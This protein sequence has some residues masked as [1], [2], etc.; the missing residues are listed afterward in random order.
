MIAILDTALRDAFQ[1]WFEIVPATDAGLRDEAFRLR[2]AVYCEDLA[3]EAPRADGREQDEYDAQSTHI[4]IRHRPSA[5]FVGCVRLIR[6]PAGGEQQRLPFERVCHGL[7][8]GAVPD[9]PERRARIAEVSRLAVSRTFR[10]RRGEANRAAPVS[11]GDFSG[12]PVLRFPYVLVG[13][14]LGVVA[15]AMLHDI[16]RLF[17]LTEPRLGEHL[18]RLGLRVVR[19]GPAVEHR[20]L[21]VPSMIDVAP[22][23]ESL[24]PMG[25]PLYEHVLASLEQAYAASMRATAPMLGEPPR[26]S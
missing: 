24:H 8:P 25:R 9:A 14:Y 15:A 6:L 11:E 16:Q 23:A 3:F 19:I 18:H 21:R 26:H 2:H 10:R 4:L 1:R 13:L 12:G 22:V 17:V 20:G 5:S 7:A